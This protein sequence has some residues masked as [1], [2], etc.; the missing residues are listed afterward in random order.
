MRW[1]NNYLMLQM[2][3][4]TYHNYTASY[5]IIILQYRGTT[6]LQPKGLYVKPKKNCHQEELLPRQNNTQVTLGL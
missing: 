2:F 5:H 6:L 4:T 3:L 1:M